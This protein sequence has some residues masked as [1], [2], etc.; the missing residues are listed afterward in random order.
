MSFKID[1]K[2]SSIKLYIIATDTEIQSVGMCGIKADEDVH[3][4]V[5]EYITRANYGL[6]IGK[7]EFDY[8]DG[9]VRYHSTLSCKDAVPSHQDVER[10]VD[11]PFMMFNRYGNGLVKALMGFGDPEADIAMAEGQQN[12]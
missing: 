11:C 3:Q 8:D 7:F 12:G 10:V 1:G 4:T 2:L 5:V 9:D 6:K